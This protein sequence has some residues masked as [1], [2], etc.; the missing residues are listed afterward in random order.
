MSM[1]ESND[2]PI[3]TRGPNPIAEIRH[4]LQA[5]EE[6]FKF[7]LPAHIPVERFVRVVM[8]AIQ[9]NSY[10]LRADR[11]SLFSAAMKAAQD[12]LLADGREGALVPFGEEVTWIPMIA[13]LRKKVRNSG[14]IATWDVAAVYAN[15]RFEFETWRYALH[16]ARSDAQESRRGDRGLFS[17]NAQGRRKIARCD[18]HR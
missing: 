12:G 10:L 6:Q 15:D 5:M 18:G 8:T 1:T 13:G 7:A 17:R 3:A 2:T 14:E 9:G 11:R 16:Q 4:G